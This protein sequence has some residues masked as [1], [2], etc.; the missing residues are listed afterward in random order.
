MSFSSPQT[1]PHSVPKIGNGSFNTHLKTARPIRRPSINPVMPS[2]AES[3]GANISGL[4]DDYDGDIRHACML[5]VVCN[6]VVLYKI[7]TFRI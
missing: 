1:G 2:Y 4:T 7:K 3:G 5:T 6:A